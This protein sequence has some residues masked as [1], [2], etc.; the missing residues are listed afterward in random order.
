MQVLGTLHMPRLG[1]FVGVY[2]VV[3]WMHLRGTENFKGVGAWF[4]W[5]VLVCRCLTHFICQ[6]EAWGLCSLGRV[7][8]ACG[9]WA[10][11]AW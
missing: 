11:C 5:P 2:R 8:E 3:G 6:G 9:M 4:Y 10:E 1:Q 7:W